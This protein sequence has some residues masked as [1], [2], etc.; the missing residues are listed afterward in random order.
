MDVGMVPAYV[1]RVSFTGDLGYE[2]WVTSDY[3]RALYKLLTETG[4]DLGLRHFGARALNS[5]RLEKSF[6]SWAR[7]YRPV[8]GPYEAGLGP[9]I[10]LKKKAFIGRSA[11]LAERESGG[12]LRL[13]TFKLAEGDADAVGDEPIY[14]DGKV[15]G[16]VTSG[17]YAHT[18]GA[19]VALG[20]VPKEVAHETSGFEI[21][22]IGERRKAT[23]FAEAI[24]DPTGERMRA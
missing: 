6:G 17:G 12:K 16:W 21:E 23:R 3:Q 11:A 5:M 20:Y 24:F 15:L 4:A 14:H 7:E 19:S 2:I 9:F 1:G 22:I 13:C 8:Y 18:A 10:S